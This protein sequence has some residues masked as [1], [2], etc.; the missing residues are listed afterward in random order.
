MSNIKRGKTPEERDAYWKEQR[1]QWWA[2]HPGKSREYNRKWRALHPDRVKTNAAKQNA[3]VTPE[4]HRKRYYADL[5]KSRAYARE[6][7]RK[8]HGIK[9]DGTCA[10]G[11]KQSEHLQNEVCLNVN[12]R[13]KVCEC[14]SYRQRRTLMRK[15]QDVM[16]KKATRLIANIGVMFAE[17]EE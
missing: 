16:D 4:M 8:K 1:K 13:D 15:S 3:K 11:H 14:A 12:K 6:W 9:D 2:K 7:F 17:D 10:C 5:E